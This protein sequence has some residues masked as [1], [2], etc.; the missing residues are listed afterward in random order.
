MILIIASQVQIESVGKVGGI[1]LSL[2]FELPPNPLIRGTFVLC[3]L[4]LG[5]NSSVRSYK[6]PR[7]GGF[8]GY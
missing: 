5:N 1:V 4:K 2:S 8:R 6:V 3:S 7:V